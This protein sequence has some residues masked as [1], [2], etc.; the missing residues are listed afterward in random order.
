MLGFH[1]G[2]A[3]RL[4]SRS[5]RALGKPTVAVSRIVARQ[6]SSKRAAVADEVAGSVA[7]AIP[8]QVATD[9]P[10]IVASFSLLTRSPGLIRV[11]TT[12][13]GGECQVL[14]AN[15]ISEVLQQRLKNSKR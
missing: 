6:M 9:P 13:D 1:V 3:A 2:R 11:Y 12:I 4:S 7:K 14:D 5:M 15:N 8:I 10:S